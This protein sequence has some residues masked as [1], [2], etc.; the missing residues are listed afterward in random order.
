MEP[1][2]FGVGGP[3]LVWP[4]ELSARLDDEHIEAIMAHEL[5]H[6][7][8]RDNLTAAL[9]MVVETVFWFHPA[10]WWMERQMVKEREQA[11]DEAV[12]AMG[13]SDPGEASEPMYVESYAEIYAE[14]LL[15]TCR[16]CIESPLVCVAGVTGADLKQRVVGIV[17]GR[18]LLRLSW[19]KK[20]LLAVA[21]VCVIAAPVVLGQ[22][23][24]AQRLMLAAMEAAPKPVQAA[25]E[26]M[27]AEAGS[28]P[29]SDE[30][31]A[32]QSAPP[33][34]EA[35]D[36]DMSL[37]PAFE[38]AVIRPADPNEKDSGS[39]VD[40]SGTFH[41]QNTTLER[42]VS[43]A[44]TH[45][46]SHGGEQVATEAPAWVHSQHFDVQA[47]LSDAEMTGW[48]KLSNFQRTEYIRP[49]LRRLLVDRFHVQLRTE[50]RETQVYVLVVAKGGSKLREVAR[51]MPEDLS[52]AEMKQRAQ[53]S[54]AH[55]APPMPES[56]T[57]SG[58][59]WSGSSMPIGMLVTEIDANV[60]PRLDA[61]LIN[62]TGL[63]GYYDF[64]MK[65]SYEKDAPPLLDQ[66]EQQLGLKVVPRKIPLKYYVITSAERPSVDG[67]EVGADAASTPS[68]KDAQANAKPLAFEVVS[69]KPSDPQGRYNVSPQVTA[70]GVTINA[71]TLTGLICVAYGVGYWQLSGIEPWMEKDR[72]DFQAKPPQGEGIAPYNERHS[73]FGIEDERLRQ[74]MQTMLADRFHLRLHRET[75]TGTVSILE[76]SGKPLLL[77]PSQMKAAKMYGESWSGD[78]GAVGGKGWSLYNTNMPQLAAF[79]GDII[80][81]HPVIDKTGLDG[82]YDFH[83]A[84]I[85]TDDDFKNDSVTSMFVPAVKEMGLKLTETKGPVDK[86]VIDHAEPP[87]EN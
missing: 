46:A 57:M 16:F 76:Q 52:D 73:N 80:L 36:A 58:D 42:L 30:A 82:S 85:M 28:A 64:N 47:K 22:A 70:D 48:G 21:A 50:Q 53:D 32:S 4:R 5:A 10:V 68:Q 2:I 87:T 18:A 24:A 35:A 27:M 83:S 39:Y 59:E 25:A 7:R 66:I 71:T 33:V 38:V 63:N 15:K 69:L 34:P 61:P 81:H 45:W 3:V 8:R 60:H 79:L 29:S 67:A 13:G 54:M 17:T 74:M 20:A 43:F 56:F 26:A 86:F 78:I 75:A 65:T 62:M 37:G 14:A 72:F 31:D 55:K 19:P 41:G 9:H 49:I 40:S 23:K 77:V 1:G 44:Y 51:P 84:T 6:V 12:V 11:C